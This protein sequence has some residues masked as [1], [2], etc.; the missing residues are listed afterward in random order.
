[1]TLVRDEVL[2]QYGGKLKAG[3][4]VVVPAQTA[5]RWREKGIAVDSAETDKTLREQ[6]IAEMQ[7]L[8]AEI[9][10]IP[11]PDDA[12]VAVAVPSGTHGRRGQRD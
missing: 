6:K 2:P 3:T 1:M 12:P 9:D 4:C 7:R 8:Q 5:R 10:A 11:E